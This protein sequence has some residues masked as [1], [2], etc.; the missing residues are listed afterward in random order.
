MEILATYAPSHPSF[1]RLLKLDVAGSSPV[2]RSGVDV[3]SMEYLKRRRISAEA[4]V[5]T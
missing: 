1:A 5:Y 4:S 3:G 2:A